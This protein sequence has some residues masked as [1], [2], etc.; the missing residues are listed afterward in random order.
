MNSPSHKRAVLCVDDSEDI[1]F[2]CKT[3][4]ESNGFEVF[5][6]CEGKAG[7]ECLNE[8][9]ID[10]AVIDLE[11]PGMNGIQL[12]QEIKHV[13]EDLPVLMFSGSLSEPDGAPIDGFLNKSEGPQAL[14]D[15]V[16]ALVRHHHSASALAAA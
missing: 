5:T 1:L 13:H 14:L 3:V 11:M 9:S 12:A 10:A 15:A 6:A 8:H 7:L 16:Q 4:L 2:I